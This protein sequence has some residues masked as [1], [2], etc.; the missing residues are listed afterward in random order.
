MSIGC[1]AEVIN[2]V[3]QPAG[4]AFLD[5]LLPILKEGV[6]DSME[7]VRRNSAYCFGILCVKSPA[8]VTP[9][10]LQILQCLYPLCIRSSAEVLSDVGGAD[11]DNALAAVSRMILSCQGVPLAQVLPVLFNALPIRSDFGEGQTVYQGIS[12]LIFNNEPSIHNC[13]PQVLGLLTDTLRSDS[14]YN[15]ET[16]VISIQTIKHLAS[17]KHDVMVSALE[18]IESVE[19]RQEIME[20][21]QHAVNS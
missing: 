3:G 20:I 4:D 10:C 9:I 2:E 5:T 15:D 12:Y 18:T 19:K 14:R 17:T 21:I 16:K 8:K 1:F 6:A 11:I 13:L 7:S